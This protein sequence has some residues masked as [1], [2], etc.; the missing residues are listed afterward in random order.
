V[1]A[2]GKVHL[3]G[4]GDGPHEHTPEANNP[5]L[6]TVD[7]QTGA[8]IG[9]WSIDNDFPNGDWYAATADRVVVNDDSLSI[10]DLGTFKSRTAARVGNI[11]Q[12]GDS[13]GEVAID[14]ANNR[15]FAFNR[16][17]YHDPDDFGPGFCIPPGNI[18][19][20]NLATGAV[21]WT[22]NQTAYPVNSTAFMSYAKGVVYFSTNYTG[23]AAPD[24]GLY[25]F[26]GATGEQ[27][28]FQKNPTGTTYGA[29]ST[30]GQLVHAVAITGGAL[31][32]QTFDAATGTPGWTSSS[33]GTVQSLGRGFEA[34]PPAYLGGL[35]VVYT[36]KTLVALDRSTGAQRWSV[37]NLLGLVA[38][39]GNHLAI[40]S[41]SG[42]VY[43]TDATSLRAFKVDDGSP[44]W[45]QSITNVGKLGSLVLVR[46]GALVF[47]ASGIVLLRSP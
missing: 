31:T 10:V 15:F 12:L 5:F 2:G 38:Q 26:D 24:S 33:L 1:S 18:S 47:G 28:W 36:G 30:D 41:A 40:S 39:N 43:L 32:I 35:L 34:D 9:N 46:G 23:G 3:H 11:C 7:F 8:S 37:P 6:Q 27:K 44:V 13:D 42:I 25:A 16:N 19:G 20:Y 14:A 45:S 29:S 22:K 4:I 17:Q 21:L